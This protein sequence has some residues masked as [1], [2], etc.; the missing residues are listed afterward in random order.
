MVGAKIAG[1]TLIL[2]SGYLFGREKEQ[3]MKKRSDFLQDMRE[4]FTYL[5]KEMTFRKTPIRESFAYAADRSSTELALILRESS[6]QIDGGEGLS[7]PFIWKEAVKKCVPKGLLSD[8][9]FETVCQSAAAL[10]NTDTVMQRTMLV[11]Y[12]ERFEVMEKMERKAYREKAGLYRRLSAA[13]GVFLVILL[14]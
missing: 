12:G 14:W 1:I 3:R 6:R 8:E 10:C 13:A 9:E 7:F 11:Q 4:L 5:E 2:L